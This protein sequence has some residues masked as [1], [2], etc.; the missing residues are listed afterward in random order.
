MSIYIIDDQDARVVY[1]GTWIKG[2]S[3]LEYNNTV[4]SSTQV[5]AFFTVSFHGTN[6]AAF[7]TM[8][9][10][11][12]GV[13]TSYSIDGATPTTASS[14]PA[15]T[16]IHMQQFWRSD[17]VSIG[18]HKLVVNM[19]KVNSDQGANEGTIWFDYFMVTDPTITSTTTV[20]NPSQPLATASTSTSPSSSP[21][22]AHPDAGIIVGAVIGGLF[23]LLAAVFIFVFYLCR[24]R[25]SASQE[26][27]V[28]ASFIPNR[29]ATVIEPFPLMMAD[30]SLSSSGVV[31]S[32]PLTSE[33]NPWI[34]VSATPP[35]AS[36]KSMVTVR[37]GTGHSTQPSIGNSSTT[38][39]TTDEPVPGSSAVD[40]IHTTDALVHSED[41]IPERG[42]RRRRLQVD[43]NAPDSQVQ[44]VSTVQLREPQPALPLQHVDSGL[45]AGSGTEGSDALTVRVE[46]P[47]V[48]SPS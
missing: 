25:P 24:R 42:K 15:S 33:F 10:T 45:R 39:F 31:T 35:A 20:P 38:N 5:G 34:S 22:G 41:S 18:D 12:G 19:T 1:N 17:D 30:A 9:I 21:N 23:L 47:P 16:D 6:I 28:E 37:P 32:A 2:G 40:G 46:L 3:S 8:D 4:A 44:L 13:E 29:R 14:Q 27:L 43:V 26:R 48:Y 11:S 7:G 36:R